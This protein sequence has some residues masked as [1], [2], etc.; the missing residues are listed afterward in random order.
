MTWDRSTG[1]KGA[2]QPFIADHPIDGDKANAGGW[3]CG[4]VGNSFHL[5]AYEVVGDEDAPYLLANAVDV[6]LVL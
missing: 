4:L 6:L 1:C 2:P 3:Q 5:Q